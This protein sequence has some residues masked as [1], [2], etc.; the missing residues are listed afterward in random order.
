[1]KGYYAKDLRCDKKVTVHVKGY[2]PPFAMFHGS[3][4]LHRHLESPPIS[5]MIYAGFAGSKTAMHTDACGTLGNNV[6]L[7]ADAGTAFTG[8][9]Y[10]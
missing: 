10:I 4:D 9:T 5:H 3:L 8:N 6:M 2:I 7:R 1:M